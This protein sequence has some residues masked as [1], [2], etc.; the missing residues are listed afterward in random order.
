[1]LLEIIAH[2]LDEKDVGEA[3]HDL[4]GAS[5]P[6]IKFCAEV[7][8]GQAQPPHTF[9]GAF[10]VKQRRQNSQKRVTRT[11]LEYHP[12]AHQFGWITAATGADRPVLSRGLSFD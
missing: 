8:G 11:I 1:M 10:D 2:G 5:P 9:L 12:A 6:T 3:G 7:C 4:A